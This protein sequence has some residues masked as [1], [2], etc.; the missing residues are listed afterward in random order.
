MVGFSLGGRWE[1]GSGRLVGSSLPCFWP[2][3]LFRM[4][5]RELFLEKRRVCPRGS[6]PVEMRVPARTEPAQGGSGEAGKQGRAWVALRCR[7]STLPGSQFRVESCCGREAFGSVLPLVE[8]VEMK[9]FAAPWERVGFRGLLVVRAT[10]DFAVEGK[11]TGN[12]N[13]VSTYNE[14]FCLIQ[15]KIHGGWRVC[16]KK[17]P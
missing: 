2:A 12:R 16:L 6:L 4:Y 10:Q 15:G 7:G 14:D 17:C 11:I 5:L 1:E 8:S 13:L 9:S 3:E